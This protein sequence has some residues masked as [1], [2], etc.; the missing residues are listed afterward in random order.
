MPDSRTNIAS[1]PAKVPAR[2][3][4]AGMLVLALGAAG[5]I[6]GCG[7]SGH[8]STTA[9]SAA[10]QT[11]G[12]QGITS[13]GTVGT[14]AAKHHGAAGGTQGGSGSAQLKEQA[15]HGGQSSS[16]G[17]AAKPLAPVIPAGAVIHTYSGVG[18]GVIGSVAERSTIVLEWSTPTPPIQLFTSRGFLLIDSHAARGRVRLGRGSYSGLR[19]AAKGSWTIRVRA[20]A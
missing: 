4:R 15:K 11:S 12:S 8:S 2:A 7:G 5:L 1:A 10:Q 18:D 3:A 13:T 17:V 16:S 19:V 20:T 6:A 9:T 14:T